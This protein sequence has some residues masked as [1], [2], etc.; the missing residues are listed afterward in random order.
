MTNFICVLPLEDNGIDLL[1]IFIPNSII[2]TD[3]CVAGMNQN[4][5]PTEFVFLTGKS[6]RLCVCKHQ[7]TRF[8]LIIGT[9]S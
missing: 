8:S 2:K 6:R 3:L 1:K 9:C 7:M 5:V 4:N